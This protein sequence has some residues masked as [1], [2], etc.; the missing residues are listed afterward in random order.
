LLAPVPPAGNLIKSQDK[1]DGPVGVGGDV[2]CTVAK[3][4]RPPA[5]ERSADALRSENPWGGGRGRK[6]QP[7]EAA[8]AGQAANFEIKDLKCR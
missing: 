7:A 5:F 2:R 8:T 3:P 1:A 6:I 4:S